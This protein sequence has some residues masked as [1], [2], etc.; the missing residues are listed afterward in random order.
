V[1]R[2][3]RQEPRLLPNEEVEL[4]AGR[5]EEHGSLNVEVNLEVLVSVELNGTC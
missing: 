3:G 2:K 1:Q 4:G 5:L